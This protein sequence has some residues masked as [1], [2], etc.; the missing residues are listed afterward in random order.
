MRVTSVI[1]ADVFVDGAKSGR[2]PLDLELQPGAHTL[3]VRGAG[4]EKK[5]SWKLSA[6]EKKVLAVPAPSAVVVP[7]AVVKKGKLHVDANPYCSLSVD[8]KRLPGTALSLWNIELNEGRHTIWCTLE[9]AS[10]PKPLVKTQPV[11]ISETQEATLK[12][13]MMEK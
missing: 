11:V 13:Q 7:P 9:D 2:T 5:V 8:G 12:F 3:F 1:E 10:F 4:V 6:G